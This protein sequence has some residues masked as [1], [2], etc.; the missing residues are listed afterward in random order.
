MVIEMR[1]YEVAFVSKKYEI[2]VSLID[3]SESVR[4]AE[5]IIHNDKNVSGYELLNGGM[6]R[7]FANAGSVK[8]F[9]SLENVLVHRDDRIGNDE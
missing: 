3:E 9:K 1:A 8:N 4:D 5:F 7:N 2:G 6:F